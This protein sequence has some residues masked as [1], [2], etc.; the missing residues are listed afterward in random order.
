MFTLVPYC[1]RIVGAKKSADKTQSQSFPE[2]VYSESC[3]ASRTGRRKVK[4]GRKSY[5]WRCC[6]LLIRCWN[7]VLCPQMPWKERNALVNK[8]KCH[9]VDGNPTK[10]KESNNSLCPPVR[11]WT[12]GRRRRT[13]STP[14]CC[15]STSPCRSWSSA[16][17]AP[18]RRCAASWSDS[19]TRP[20]SPTS[21]NTTSAGSGSWGASTSWRSGSSPRA[22]RYQRGLGCELL[23]VVEQRY[24]AAQFS[25]GGP[26]SFGARE[27]A[28]VSHFVTNTF[29]KQRYLSSCAT[30]ALQALYVWTTAV[31]R[32]GLQCVI[33]RP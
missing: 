19:S 30:A 33:G 29:L 23:G 26:R 20:S 31:W 21:W 5:W 24:V 8:A 12:K 9:I 32:S 11:S 14:C 28:E 18:S 17:S 2:S 27:F 13:W 6:L 25:S 10:Y 3:W 22:S 1:G 4:W 15:A 16:I 7:S